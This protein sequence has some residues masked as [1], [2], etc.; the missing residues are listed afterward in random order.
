MMNDDSLSNL[1]TLD[2]KIASAISD[3]YEITNRFPL[4][5][6]IKHLVK[7]PIKTKSVLADPSL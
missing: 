1:I 2:S 4:S 6:T 7:Y 5:R 3:N